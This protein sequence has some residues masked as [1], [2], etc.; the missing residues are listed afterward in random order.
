M[1]K[2][3]STPVEGGVAAGVASLDAARQTHAVSFIYIVGAP[4]NAWTACSG[5]CLGKRGTRNQWL[6]VI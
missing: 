1:Q 6:Q 3:G 5:E 4:T 2:H